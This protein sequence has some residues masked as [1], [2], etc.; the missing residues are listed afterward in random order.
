M[1]TSEQIELDV[2]FLHLFSYE[3]L[4]LLSK[5]DLW[6]RVH[7]FQSTPGGG[8]TSLLRL[9]TPGALLTL[10]AHRGAEEFKEL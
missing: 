1:Q 2:D 7:I 5:E 4:D 10:L 9:F 8:K 3:A 6:N